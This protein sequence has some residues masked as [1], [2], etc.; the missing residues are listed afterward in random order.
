LSNVYKQIRIA[1]FM[2]INGLPK[3]VKVLVIVLLLAAF[4]Y[5][6][7]AGQV[8]IG[9]PPPTTEYS[10]I[11]KESS[12]VGYKFDATVSVTHAPR[13]FLCAGIPHSF[14]CIENTYN[15]ETKEKTSRQIACE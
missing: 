9:F 3:W 15:K 1:L 10:W 5:P 11:D 2:G 6:K 13:S 12:C 8:G 4:F 14:K 7:P